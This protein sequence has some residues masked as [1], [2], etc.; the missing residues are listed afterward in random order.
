LRIEELRKK[1]N[2]RE[3]ERLKRQETEY[4]PALAR[5]ARKGA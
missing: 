4:G 3:Q 5:F 1:H 2:V